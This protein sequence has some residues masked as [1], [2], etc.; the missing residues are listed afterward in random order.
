VVVATETVYRIK[1]GSTIPQR[2]AAVLAE[3][4]AAVAARHEGTV[5]PPELV[6]AARPK[7]ATLHRFF[8]WDNKMAAEQWRL[9]WARHLLNSV[10]KRIVYRKADADAPAEPRHVRF[11]H[12]VHIARDDGVVERR[13]APLELV[14]KRRDLLAEVIENAE[15][16]IHGWQRRYRDYRELPNFPERLGRVLDILEDD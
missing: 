12:S 3:G 13:Y 9:W 6:D 11:M 7:D 4:I 8:E 10:E 16:E 15:R 1:R 14:I 2:D 5:S